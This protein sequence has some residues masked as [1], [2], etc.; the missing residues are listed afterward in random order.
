MAVVNIGLVKKPKDPFQTSFTIITYNK[1]V[2]SGNLLSEDYR[3][4]KE[5]SDRLDF[6]NLVQEIG[7]FNKESYEKAISQKETIFKYK[8]I[9][10]H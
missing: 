9:T 5:T 1:E 2:E 7:R 3:E 4:T 8:I 6:E 10:N